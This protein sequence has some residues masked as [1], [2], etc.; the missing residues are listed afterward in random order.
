[1]Q[2]FPKRILAPAAALML[3]GAVV[4]AGC[5]QETNTVKTDTTQ[6]GQVDT[7]SIAT[8][9]AP[10]SA[11][12]TDVPY[13]PTSPETVNR[14]LEMANVTEQDTVYDLGSGDGRIVIAAAQQYGAHGVG[15]EIDPKRI[16]AARKNAKMADVTDLVEFRQGDL[17]KADLSEATVVTLYLLPSVNKK[18]R[19]KLMRELEPGTP[20]VSHDFDMG[21]WEP[22]RTVQL[23]DDT[24]YRWTIPEGGLD[25]SSSE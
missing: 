2:L 22:E 24:V 5:A 4:L 6:Q 25:N 17:F 8:S 23:G 14:M 19:P 15:V 10:D 21:S 11:V 13:V 3:V 18:L 20:V 12:D 9:T 7:S 1:M 16:E